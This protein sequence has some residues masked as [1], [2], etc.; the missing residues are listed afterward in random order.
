MGKG[1][2]QSKTFWVNAVTLAVSVGTY[3]MNSELFVNNP[4]VVAIGGAVIGGL[5]I[6]LRLMTGKPITGVVSGK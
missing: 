2:L 1:L 6:L 4:E 5:N 3:L